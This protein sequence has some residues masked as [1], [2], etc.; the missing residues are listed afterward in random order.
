MSKKILFVDD[1]EMT[2]QVGKFM[3]EALGYNV[4]TAE[5]GKAALDILKKYKAH[6]I[7]LDVMMPDINGIDVLQAL[8]ADKKLKSIPVV[9]QTGVGNQNEINEMMKLGATSIIRKPYNKDKLL[10]IIKLTLQNSTEDL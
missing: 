5:S 8:K 6:L 2:L 10:E 7:F 1:D 3:L 9:L 4:V